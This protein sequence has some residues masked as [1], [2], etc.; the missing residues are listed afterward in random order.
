MNLQNLAA[1]NSLLQKQNRAPP[2]PIGGARAPA[3]KAT[4]QQRKAPQG[5][6]PQIDQQQ[7]QKQ[8]N[9]PQQKKQKQQEKP[10]TAQKQEEATF[11]CVPCSKSFKTQEA[12]E[13]H[14]EDHEE[15]SHVGCDFSASSGVM[16]EHRLLHTPRVQQW[17]S[18]TPEE[19]AQWR[20]ERKRNWPTEENLKRKREEE[21]KRKAE[22]EE[23]KKKRP[24]SDGGGGDDE[25]KNKRGGVKER[26]H[27]ARQQPE[28][29]AKPA[30]PSLLRSL[31]TT[32]R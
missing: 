13:I 32:E 12:F 2:P 6:R 24:R 14:V 23:E 21:A 19:I 18:M 15:C 8:R 20:E 9:Q 10:S 1:Y 16:K 25:L 29:R 7:Q 30:K 4:N 22:E 28:R 27:P 26:Q 11:V 5:A 17:M 31:F 3:K